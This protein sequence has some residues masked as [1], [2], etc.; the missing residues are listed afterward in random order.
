MLKA[1]LAGLTQLEHYLIAVLL[2]ETGQQA[3]PVWVEWHN[4]WPMDDCLRDW[5]FIQP[6][7]F[8]LM[9]NLIMA[10]GGEP[11]DVCISDSDGDIIHA[12]ITL[13]TNGST[14]DVPARPNDA[15]TFATVARLP[16]LMSDK[17]LQREGVW[18]P[19]PIRKNWRSGQV[20]P[21]ASLKWIAQTAMDQHT[22]S[23][24]QVVEGVYI[25]G[26]RRRPALQR[27]RDEE[28]THVLKLYHMP[29][30]WP[31]DFDVLDNSLEDGALIPLDTLQR[32]VQFIKKH[33]D[34]N[35]KVLV[36]CW[37]G[38]SRSSTFVLAYLVQELGYDLHE[39]WMLLRQKHAKAW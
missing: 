11:R 23:L 18:V 4:W 14:F 25:S 36:L 19:E 21:D 13:C 12:H 1:V 15:I 29:V 5:R 17:V 35:E 30:P 39:A 34:Q 7:C 32:G 10:S 9:N 28:I 31:D 3:L 37:E 6:S 20:L 33:R 22:F 2:D 24:D 27:L 38:V 26:V 16:I 8:T